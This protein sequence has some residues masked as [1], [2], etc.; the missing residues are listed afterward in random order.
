[1]AETKVKQKKKSLSKRKKALLKIGGFAL[2]AVLLAGG[3]WFYYWKKGPPNIWYVEKGLED[4]WTRFLRE[5]ELPELFKET[6]VWD[7]DA[8]PKGPGILIAT[9]P[10]QNQEK[11]TVYYHLS[12]DLEY[13]GAHVLALDP[14]MI[15]R[16]HTD[17]GLTAARIFSST[18]GNIGFNRAGVL[19]IPGKDTASVRAWTAR[20]IQAGPGVFP[21]D[22]DL[23]QEQENKL[24]TTNRFPDGAQTYNWP[25]VFFRLM[26]RETAWVYTPLSVIRRYRNS[27]KSI[28]EATAFPEPNTDQYSLQ[29]TLLWAIPLGSPKEQERT[30]QTIVWLKESE[31]QTAIADILEWIPA[32]PYGEPY[33]PVSLSSHRNWVTATYIYEVNE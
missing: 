31:T 2:F 32:N 25:D 24:F 21:A 4:Y 11:V 17:P 1:M 8:I 18:G 19:L 16:K 10:W 23:W 28:L 29:A 12:I 22:E 15:F 7:G 30:E 5:S 27:R 20:L 9:K 3:I 33:D 26:G 13:E 14:W 6:R